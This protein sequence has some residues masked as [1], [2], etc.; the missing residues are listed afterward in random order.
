MLAPRSYSNR[1]VCILGLGRSGC[2]SA[3]AL[4]QAGAQVVGW[5]DDP[6]RRRQAMRQGIAVAADGKRAC[7]QADMLLPAPGIPLTHPRPHPLVALARA[8]DM[9]ILGDVQLFQ[10]VL[11]EQKAGADWIAIT[12]TNGKSTTASLVAH[13]LRAA[14]LQVALGGNIGVPALTLPPPRDGL[15]YVLE[16]SSFQI[17]LAPSLAPQIAVQLNVTADHLDRHGSMSEYAAVKAGLFAHLGRSHG[18]RHRR[19]AAIVGIDDAPGRELLAQLQQ[20]QQQ[21]DIRL[22]ALAL[23][24]AVLPPAL[25]SVRVHD[26]RLLDYIRPDDTKGQ[27]GT[28]DPGAHDLS[29]IRALMGRHNRQNMAAAF[30]VGRLYGL[31]GA[32]IIR[33]FA[34][35]SPPPHRMQQVADIDGVRFINDSKATNG[36][37]AARSLQ[38]FDHVHW[39]LGGIPKSDGIEPARRFFGKIA[40]AYLIGTAQEK[41]AAVLQQ[42]GVPHVC[43]GNLRAATRAAAEDALAARRDGVVLLAPA[44]ASFDQFADFAARGDAFRAVVEDLKRQSPPQ[45]GG[46][47]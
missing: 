1:K 31:P 11:D 3:R 23:E 47:P 37:A 27:G 29:G 20:T 14:D 2:A 36:E 26:D 8:A 40:C 24:E 30:A 25:E 22:I 43:C 21:K 35:F 42:E 28:P 19:A 10:H 4:Q 18:K 17:E 16:L 13:I 6:D 15:I 38:C 45:S 39:I 41:F 46:A 12:G 33:S 5:D 32:D 44:C 34:D 9:E 7:T